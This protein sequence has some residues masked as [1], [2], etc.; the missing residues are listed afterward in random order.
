VHGNGF[1]QLDLDYEG[2]TRLHVWDKDV[3]RQKVATPIH[4]HVFALRSHVIAGTLIHEELETYTPS[5]FKPTHKVYRAQQE[6]GTQNTILVPDD[7][8][9][10]LNVA[11]RLVLGVGSVYTFPAWKL[12]QTDH[13][14]L[15]ATIM[16]KI[17][18]PQEYGRPRVLVPI[19]SQ[20]DNEFHRDGFDPEILWPFIE[21][22]LRLASWLERE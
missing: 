9:V 3:P 11:E 7:G 10:S 5:L 4:D 14:G 6:E 2:T 17:N 16:E 20:P 18:A 21:R 22:A 15:T 1:I 19:G 8:A 12:H 13:V